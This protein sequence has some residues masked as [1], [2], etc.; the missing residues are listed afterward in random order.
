[1]SDADF[2]ALCESW[3]D[4]TIDAVQ[5]AQLIALVVA[6]PVLRTALVDAHRQHLALRGLMPGGE[7]ADRNAR[8]DQLIDAAAPVGRQRRIDA[9]KSS[10]PRSGRTDRFANRAPAVWWKRALPIAAALL[11]AAG[12]AAWALWPERS[13]AD[14]AGSGL[15]LR[16][17]QRL[18]IAAGLSLRDG[19]RIEAAAGDARVYYA[20]GTV[21]TL[22]DGA[23]ATIRMGAIGKRVELAQGAL[24]AVVMP[25]SAGRPLRLVAAGA[26]AEVLGTEL[27]FATGADLARVSVLSGSVR[28]SAVGGAV[29]VSA[30]QTAVARAGA[31][32]VARASADLKRGLLGWWSFDEREGEH[33]ADRSAAGRHARASRTLIVD[34]LSGRA[35]RFD[36]AFGGD[37]YVQ[38]TAIPMAGVDALSVSAWVRT[39]SPFFGTVVGNV[40]TVGFG[41]GSERFKPQDMPVDAAQHAGLVNLMHAATDNAHLDSRT[42]VDDGRWHH[43]LW[44]WRRGGEGRI[45]IDGR[46]SASGPLTAGRWPADAWTPVIGSDGDRR[47]WCFGGDIDEVRI[48][49]GALDEDTIAQLAAPQGE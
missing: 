24:R 23:L 40:F 16:D 7:Q 17:D 30:G 9:I 31:M 3:L 25:Q 46:L 11:I 18:P 33:A 4:G 47:V 27:I 38:A 1:M 10:L 44:I 37:S 39:T 2:S 43:L 21:L 19:D 36:G 13:G 20:D 48:Y 49:A 41:A 26:E 22:R 14:I 34:G 15:V 5:R 8:I 29:Q 45:Y 28:L 32:P 12:G 42:R 6:D 35:R